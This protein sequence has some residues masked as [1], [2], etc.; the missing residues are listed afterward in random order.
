MPQKSEHFE[1]SKVNIPRIYLKSLAAVRCLSV[2]PRPWLLWVLLQL[3][4]TS[5]MLPRRLPLPGSDGSP[6][7]WAAVLALS[8][9]M[10]PLRTGLTRW[11]GVLRAHVHAL[12]CWRWGL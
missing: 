5:A 7:D 3:Y 6:T 4:L 1:K 2:C 8:V 11:S 12:R 9:Q 10:D